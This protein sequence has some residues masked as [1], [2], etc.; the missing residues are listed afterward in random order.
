MGFCGL[1]LHSGL[2][3]RAEL[4]EYVRRR[5]GWQGIGQARQVVADTSEQAATAMTPPPRWSGQL[6]ASV[7]GCRAVI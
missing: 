4:H 5:R 3:E 6:A 1:L 2:V 7:A